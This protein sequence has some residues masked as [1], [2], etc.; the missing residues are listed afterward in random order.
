M[1]RDIGIRWVLVLCQM[2]SLLLPVSPCPEGCRCMHQPETD[3]YMTAC[4]GHNFTGIPEGI[5]NNTAELYIKNQGFDTLYAD[6]FNG[7]ASLHTLV[8]TNCMIRQIEPNAFSGLP[9]LGALDLRWNEISELQ[10]Y[11]FSGLFH[12]R[13]LT[14]DNNHLET[15]HNFAFH[16]LSLTR[17]SLENNE[18]LTQIAQKAFHGAQVKELYFYNSSITSVSTHALLPLVDSLRVLHWQR[19]QRALEFPP[20][21]FQGFT[22]RS[23][24]LNQNS[25][26]D[27]TFLEHTV[28]DDLS[29][30]N[31]PIGPLVLSKYP[32]LRQ[33]RI[34]RLSHTNFHNIKPQYLEGM[35]H[36]QQ[37][38]L[39]SN[40]IAY[41]SS[42][43]EFVFERLER[44]VLS[45]NPL[46]CNCE[47][48]WLR[49]WMSRTRVTVIGA[50]CKM[51]RAEDV[52][53]LSEESFSC[54][55]PNL[56]DI[57][58][59]M[60]LT[61]DSSF[62]LNCIAQGDPA[63]TIIWELP[64]GQ[65]SSTLPPKNK[66]VTFNIGSLNVGRTSRSD[67]G[68]YKCLAINMEGNVSGIANIDVYA[69]PYTM[70]V[71]VSWH[72]HPALVYSCIFFLLS[73]VQSL[74]HTW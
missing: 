33:V 45:D 13:Q 1:M 5:P 67:A 35:S 7:M 58:R 55:A 27:V 32:E 66:S 62:K 24:N 70:A 50:T 63:P 31:N 68:M 73:I 23:L 47:L 69:A 61:E 30:E 37:L 17:L 22:F 21:V 72:L 11:T 15:I 8:L 18:R 43:M 42:D 6:S 19:N 25:I 2:A 65:V 52:L 12:L 71:A 74:F 38:Y 56:V 57:T 46:H 48:L 49:R 16:G 3:T 59:S 20:D 4:V 39:A 40:N 10:S 60:N 29:L 34:L 26:R 14:I 41:L 54:T 44:L 28:A 53:L 36:L 51:P 64:G 9:V